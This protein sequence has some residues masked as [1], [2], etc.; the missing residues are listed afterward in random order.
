MLETLRKYPPLFNLDRIAQNDY[1]VPDTNIVIEKG[2][3]V[4]I[5]SY[6]I[7]HDAEYYAEPEKFDPDRFDG[8]EAKKRDAMTWLPFGDGP[9]NCIGARF[10]MMQARIG[11]VCL[12]RNFEITLGS[13]TKL[14]IVF[15][16]KSIFLSPEG[17]MYLRL[18]PIC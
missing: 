1:H 15:D 13:K 18:K 16:P 7:Q 3:L 8:E 14:P 4:L 11:I 9:R 12:L 17:G 5:P 6:A 2:T 10:G